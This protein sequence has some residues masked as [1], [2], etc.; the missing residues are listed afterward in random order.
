[1]EIVEKYFGSLTERQKERFGE[2]GRLYAE[3]NARLNVVSR[4]DTDALYERHV[5][6]SLG[7]AKVWT[8]ADGA[9]VC[10]VGTGG[11][12]PAV[13]LAIMFPGAHFTAVDSIGKKIRVVREI[14][15]ALE[16]DNLEAV[17]ARAESL[18]GPWDYAVSRAVAP[19]AQL[20][21]WVWNGIRR[22]QAGTLPNGL[23]CLKGGDLRAEL[24]AAGR[25][26]ESWPLSDFFTEEFFDA[27]Y[28][29]YFPK[30]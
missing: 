2:L 3:W 14:A 27:K 9:R 30:K 20:V 4:R 16:L 11:G 23:L 13:P 15:S 12:F 8:P 6:H 25:P 28:A 19:A 5:L 26:Y 18:R 21:R 22:G 24:D 7:L 10:D 1:M 29:V 17:C